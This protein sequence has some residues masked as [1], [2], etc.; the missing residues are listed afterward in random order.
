[1]H[2]LPAK[3]R[4]LLTVR[5][6]THAGWLVCVATLAALAACNSPVAPVA[7]LDGTWLG[8]NPVQFFLKLAQNGGQIHVSGTIARSGMYEGF[9]LDVKGA[10]SIRA[11]STLR[12]DLN[13][14]SG[15]QVLQAKLLPTGAI[16]GIISG[17]RIQGDGV[18][19]ITLARYVP[20]P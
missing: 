8:G 16:S 2:I 10:G 19:T 17:D 12:I 3:P 1:M 20:T 14:T 4:H 9:V 5:V 11:D 18:Q 13:G 15:H 6:K 7:S